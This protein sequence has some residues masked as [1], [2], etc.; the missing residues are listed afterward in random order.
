MSG[1]RIVVVEDEPLTRA[2]MI[3][4]LEK[5][6]FAVRP[7]ADV[8]ACRAALRAA[9]ADVVILDLGLPG[10]DGLVL[11]RELRDDP[12][13]DVI[14]VTMRGEPQE[15][16]A[17]L[18]SGAD[19]YLVKPVHL[20]ELA[21]R[22]RAIERRRQHTRQPSYCFG[23]FTLDVA[24]RALLD[25][26]QCPVPITRGEYEVLFQL[27]SANGKIVS[28]EMLSQVASR[29]H[30][31]GAD[32]RSADALVSRL[33]KKLGDRALIVTAPGFGYRLLLDAP[34]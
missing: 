12:E 2:A 4:F 32:V 17:A 19:D 10:P 8:P 33:R 23:G 24:Q 29:R 14:V 25:A 26:S 7:A 1:C 9:P 34:R 30:Q 22:I 20:G 13:T 28:R 3:T 21:A 18:D 31:D 6:G 5:E 15:R 16:I 27:A 11:A